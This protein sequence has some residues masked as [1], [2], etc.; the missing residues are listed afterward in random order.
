VRPQ[1]NIPPREVVS[2]TSPLLPSDAGPQAAKHSQ[3]WRS[4]KGGRAITA[5]RQAKEPGCGRERLQ[6]EYSG[7]SDSRLHALPKTGRASRALYLCSR[8]RLVLR[9]ST[10]LPTSITAHSIDTASQVLESGSLVA[11]ARR[12]LGLPTEKT[13]PDTEGSCECMGSQSWTVGKGGPPPPD[14]I[15]GL[16]TAPNCYKGP[17]VWKNSD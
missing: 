10:R 5:P 2:I 12:V 8:L 11:M 4:D 14:A 13:P 7:T 3:R 15:H 1:R 9:H 6:P 17:Q 16:R